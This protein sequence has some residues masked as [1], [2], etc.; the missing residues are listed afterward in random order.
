[1][2]AL[3]AGASLNTRFW[4]SDA[5]SGRHVRLG[6]VLVDTTAAVKGSAL[7]TAIGAICTEPNDREHASTAESATS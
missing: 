5:V 7:S 4:G 2:I 1:M 3:A 6:V